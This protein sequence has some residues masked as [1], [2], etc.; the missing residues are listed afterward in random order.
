ML[1]RITIFLSWV[2][3]L[4][5]NK[6]V[7]NAGNKLKMIAT[8]TTGLDHIDTS[9]AERKGIQIISL[10][11]EHEFLDAITG[12]AELALGLMVILSRHIYP[13]I[14]AVRKGAWKRED[15]RG[16]SLSERTLGI[17]G[18]GR[19]GKIMARY[20]H[21]LGMNVLFADPHVDKN[22]FPE[23]RKVS[24]DALLQESDI[25]SI[26]THLSKET[27]ALFDKNAFEKMKPEAYLINTSRD[28]IVDERALIHAL[29][30]GNLAG[31]GT[32]VL[33]GEIDF[34]G[35]IP[36]AHPLWNYALTHPNVIIVPHI[37]GM[38]YE[39][40]VKTDIHI[41]NKI[42]MVVLS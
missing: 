35:K 3:G 34:G 21:M 8:A 7:I 38:T 24:F 22:A 20:G 26:H 14:E 23:Y 31:Y 4:H 33:S 36:D 32:D 1:F 30:A 11:G 28:K 12:T 25:V 5:I 42:T 2:L 19:L 9:F 29:E 17:V 16:H 15:S 41:A 37:G 27:I 40:R 18:M 39:S 10:K 13:A 6:K